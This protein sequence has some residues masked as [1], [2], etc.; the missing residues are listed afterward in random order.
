MGFYWC[1]GCSFLDI[2]CGCLIV[3]RIPRIDYFIMIDN[4][5]KRQQLF[6]Q[7]IGNYGFIELFKTLRKRKKFIELYPENF[8][9]FEY[10]KHLDSLIKG[11]ESKELQKV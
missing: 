5:E 11:Q 1:L 6:A 4:I 8:L 10:I 7:F 3:I 9:G 2:L